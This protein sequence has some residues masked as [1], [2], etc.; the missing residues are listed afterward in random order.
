M[1]A[2]ASC[3]CDEAMRG[4]QRE[5][6]ELGCSDSA[7]TEAGIAR[8]NPAL[9]FKQASAFAESLEAR[10]RGTHGRSGAKAAWGHL[11]RRACAPEPFHGEQGLPM[12]GR[13]PSALRGFNRPPVRPRN[14]GLLSPVL[15]HESRGCKAAGGAAGGPGARFA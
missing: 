6:G 5:G 14:K 15:K 4:D 8:R 3:A 1:N 7:A 11:Q 2:L 13:S 9:P 10:L 12:R